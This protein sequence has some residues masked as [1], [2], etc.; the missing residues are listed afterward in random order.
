MPPIDANECEND[1][2]YWFGQYGRNNQLSMEKEKCAVKGIFPFGFATYLLFFS[3][4]LTCFK[5]K[6]SGI[7][8]TSPLNGNL[9][10]NLSDL[11]VDRGKSPLRCPHVDYPWRSLCLCFRLASSPLHKAVRHSFRIVSASCVWP[12][13]ASNL[14]TKYR[15]LRTPHEHRSLKLERLR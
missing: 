10:C 2:I 13:V 6:S 11:S 5:E 14:M 12:K 1:L 4:S 15:L 3:S 8:S 9:A 7:Y